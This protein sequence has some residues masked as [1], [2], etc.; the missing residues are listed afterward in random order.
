[1]K[2]KISKIHLW[3]QCEEENLFKV[4]CNLFSSATDHHAMIAI[5]ANVNNHLFHQD[6]FRFI[7]G[8]QCFSPKFGVDSCNR[9]N[10]ECD[11]KCSLVSNVFQSF[12]S[13]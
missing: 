6:P 1:M 12:L 3:L 10:C 9:M 5:S 2:R 8:W 11:Q 13:F 7:Y 4:D